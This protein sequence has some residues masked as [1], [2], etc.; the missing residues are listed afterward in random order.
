M[1]LFL[2]TRVIDSLSLEIR[3]VFDRFDMFIYS[4]LDALSGY[5]FGAALPTVNEVEKKRRD[6]TYLLSMVNFPEREALDPRMLYLKNL[7]D[8]WWN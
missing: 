7:I 1:F 8:G 3:D 6:F 2:E 4:T 5:G